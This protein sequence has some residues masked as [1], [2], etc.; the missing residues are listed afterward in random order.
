MPSV[1][2]PLGASAW[3]WLGLWARA[4][5]PLGRGRGWNRRMLPPRTWPQ[6]PAFLVTPQVPL[7]GLPTA[8]EGELL[9]ADSA[10]AQVSGGRAGAPASPA[11]PSAASWP[12]P[13]TP[14]LCLPVPR[15]FGYPPAVRLPGRPSTPSTPAVAPRGGS[16]SCSASP[17]RTQSSGEGVPCSCLQATCW[18]G[19]RRP[20]AIYPSAP[21]CAWGG[22]C[23]SSESP[24]RKGASEARPSTPPDAAPGG[25]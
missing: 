5:V 23:R 2:Q 17:R 9:R 24:N 16:T 6:V 21:S 11:A 20:Q 12:P 15:L 14:C 10:A 8:V 13:P 7:R 1:P 19:R 4:G 22:L 25:T 18:K 3:L